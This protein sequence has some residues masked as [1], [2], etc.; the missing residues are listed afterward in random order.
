VTRPRGVT[1]HDTATTSRAEWPTPGAALDE[2]TPEALRYFLEV[3]QY[4][5]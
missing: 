1:G 5:V 4:E 3:G 2:N